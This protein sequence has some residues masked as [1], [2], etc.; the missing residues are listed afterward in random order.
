MKCVGLAFLGI[1]WDESSELHRIHREVGAPAV[2]RMVTRMGLK[3]QVELEQA[4]R[5]NER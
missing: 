2:L 1:Q 5:A 4:S 3:R